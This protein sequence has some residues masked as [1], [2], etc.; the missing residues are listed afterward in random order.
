MPTQAAQVSTEL[1]TSV[2]SA[3][4][5]LTNP[6]VLGSAFFGSKVET[7][8]QVGSPI[9]F[10]GELGGMSF[11]NIGDVLTFSPPRQLRL[12]HRSALPDLEDKPLNCHVVTF[13]LLP[14]ARA[15]AKTKV[16]YDQVLDDVTRWELAR[17]WSAILDGLKRAAE[18]TYGRR[19]N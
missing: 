5:A 8:W 14:S 6:D 17:N 16:R 12:T 19:D 18:R 7:T 10:R 3:W 2:E 1:E 13:D 15:D 11:E 9:P 4:K